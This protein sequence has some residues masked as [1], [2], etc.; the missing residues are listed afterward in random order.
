MPFTNPDHFSL[1]KFRIV[2][3]KLEGVA[4][5]L[6]ALIFVQIGLMATLV[7]GTDSIKFMALFTSRF[8]LIESAAERVFSA[9][10][11][12]AFVY[13]L[14]RVIEVVNI[15]VA[16]LKLQASIL[17][18]A[19]ATNNAKAFED[20]QRHH[21]PGPVVGNEGFGRPLQ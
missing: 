7:G 14:V 21:P 17:D 11:G 20:E 8:P 6:R 5:K 18:A 9:L 4:R 19:I 10:I 12:G 1:E 15:D 16:L 13:A 3:A 2:A